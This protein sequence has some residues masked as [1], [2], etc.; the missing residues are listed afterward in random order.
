MSVWQAYR[1]ISQSAKESP[2][3]AQSA[4][5]SNFQGH[6]SLSR[7]GWRYLPESKEEVEFIAGELASAGIPV[8]LYTG[9]EGTEAS[10]K[11][12]SGSPVSL[13][14]MA[15][16]GFFV[17]NGE[18]RDE[19]Y[20]EQF[21]LGLFPDRSIDP[22]QRSGLILSGGQR[23]WL[24]GNTTDEEDDGILTAK[25]IADM[26]FDS[27]SIVV[28]SACETALGD[29]AQEGVW[30]LQWAFK[31]AGADCMLMSL[32]EVNDQA[33]SLLMREFYKQLLI[34]KPKR[35]AVR[36]AQEKVKAWNPSPYYWAAFLMIE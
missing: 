23:A 14:H 33:T 29:I 35:E 15:T 11:T 26:H 34:G 21:R 18:A 36:M 9:M 19:T 3:S 2:A 6:D 17:P 4:T 22:L 28:L 24:L 13:L 16:H 30:G 12:L 25:E 27:L 5:S 7:Q 10:F 31:L 1:S 32:W 20:F 8:K